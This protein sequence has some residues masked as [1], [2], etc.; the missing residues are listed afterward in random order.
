MNFF[1]DK[2]FRIWYNISIL[3]NVFSLGESMGRKEFEL[4][5]DVLLGMIETGVTKRQMGEALGIS[6]PTLRSKIAKLQEK[7]PVLL[8]YRTLQTLELTELQ[9]KILSKITDDK[10]DNAP[11]RDLVL[12]YKILKEKEFMVEGKP[13][14]I[15]GLVHYLIEIEKM[16][17]A[18]K[19]AIAS[20][21]MNRVNGD[22]D[23]TDAEF[24]EL[25]GN[26]ED[27]LSCG[28]RLCDIPD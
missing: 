24:E 19:N 23:I 2:L 25:A 7:S 15:K 14:E 12:A 6:Q 4:D 27:V 3:Y 18:E 16:E 8:E 13:T 9:S 28:V 11:L 10:I 26:T 1:I 20:T 17:Q 5:A 21:A 22:G